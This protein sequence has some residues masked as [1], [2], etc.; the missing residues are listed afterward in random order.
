M[1]SALTEGSARPGDPPDAGLTADPPGTGSTM[2][3]LALLGVTREEADES[4]AA[5][6]ACFARSLALRNGVTEVSVDLSRKPARGFVLAMTYRTGSTVLKDWLADTGVLGRPEE[7]LNTRPG[8]LLDQWAATFRAEDVR[9][10]LGSIAA[11][12]QT[13]NAVFGIKAEFMQFLPVILSDSIDLIG[14]DVR[15]VYVERRD[16]LAQAVSLATARAT[17]KWNTTMPVRFDDEIDAESIVG[18]MFEITRRRELWERFFALA[19]VE[20][21]R[22]VYEE[23]VV[24]PRNTIAKV[25]AHLDCPLSTSIGAPTSNLEVQRDA[26]SAEWKAR[27][28]RLFDEGDDT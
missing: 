7:Y 27:F 28:R 15:F 13:P 6:S 1:A 25:A 5:V 10:Y 18:C 16:L 8:N 21:L 12:H 19:G 2:N 3:R 22:L 23:M 26:L 24:D 20:P 9:S 11:H 4:R 14:S 17:G